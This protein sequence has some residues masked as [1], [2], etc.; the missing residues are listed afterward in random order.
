[1]TLGGC[2]GLGKVL[3]HEGQCES[4]PSS[5]I[6]GVDGLIPGGYHGAKT[7]EV[8][9]NDQ[10]FGR[11]NFLCAVDL[12]LRKRWLGR[13]SRSGESYVPEAIGAIAM[14]DDGGSVAF[15]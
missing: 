3:A 15:D 8:Q 11:F 6:A 2:D 12:R 4:G 13:R 14:A 1:M 7:G 5:K 10:I 9:I